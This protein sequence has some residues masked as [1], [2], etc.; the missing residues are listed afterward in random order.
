MIGFLRR[1]WAPDRRPLG[2]RGESA[3]ARHLRKAGYRIVSRNARRSM[4]EIDLIAETPE[5]DTLVVVEVKSRVVDAGGGDERSPER[6]I[7]RAKARTLASLA[8][9]LARLPASR[10]RGIRVD[11]VAVEFVEGRRDPVAVRH[12]P[13]AINADGGRV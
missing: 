12:Y 9:D 2:A 7:T 13:N 11:V 5:R 8:R 6:A 10:G 1:R 3:A 4:G